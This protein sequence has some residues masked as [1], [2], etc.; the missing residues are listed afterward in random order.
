M[1]DDPDFYAWLDGEL[2]GEAGAAMARRVAVDPELSRQAAEHRALAERLRGAFDPILQAPVPERLAAAARPSTVVDLA[3]ER[4]RR[5]PSPWLQFTAMAASLAIG[6][7]TGATLLGGSSGPIR[8]DGSRLLAA[9]ELA[10]A[11]DT[12]LASAPEGEATRIGLT[13]RDSSGRPCRTFTDPASSG[14]ACREGEQWRLRGLFEAP[15]GQGGEYRLAS[16]QD[17]RLLALVEETMAGEP[18]GP[19]A[20]AQAVKRGWR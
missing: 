16:G 7:F 8:Q 6:L 5:R 11:L 15:E 9:G 2:E 1:T 17:P 20:E 10:Q 4:S 13:F 3:A 14:L 18:L 12:R 19:E